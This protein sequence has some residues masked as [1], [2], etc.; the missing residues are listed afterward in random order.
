MAP[1][2]IPDRPAPEP[3]KHWGDCWNCALPVFTGETILQMRDGFW[4]YQCLATAAELPEGF[5]D[6]AGLI[7]PDVTLAI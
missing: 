6:C 7:L 1:P 2:P 5:M 3:A 4:C